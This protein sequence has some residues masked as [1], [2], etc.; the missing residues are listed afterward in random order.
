MPDDATNRNLLVAWRDGDQRAA[1]VLVQRYMLRLMALARSRLSRKLARRID[2][3]DIV[4]SAWRSFF[5]GARF[6]KLSPSDSDDLWPL[7]VTITLRKLARQ[8]TRHAANRRNAGLEVELDETI[9]WHRTVS[10]DPSPSEAALLVDEV[11]SLM[12]RLDQVDRD[13][14]IR[15]LQGEEQSEIAMAIGCSER[16]VRRSMQR[17][18]TLMTEGDAQTF[19]IQNPDA[20]PT[21]RSRTASE[22]SGTEV[23]LQPTYSEKDITL[24]KLIGTGGFGKV[25]RS[26]CRT[27]G[28]MVAVKFLKKQFWNDKRARDRLLH[29]A[30]LIS[31]VSHPAII[32]HF[33]WGMTG[34]GGL[35]IVMDWIDG[36]NAAEWS[37][38]NRK[39][40]SEII[41]CGIVVAEA[42]AAAHEAGLIHGDLTPNNVLRGTDGRFVLTDFG[43]AKLVGDTSQGAVGG[44]PGFLAP[45]QISDSYGPVGFHTDV[46]GFGGMLYALLTGIAPMQGRDTP[47]ILANVL[48]SRSPP[49]VNEPA[50]GIPQLLDDL[51]AA[52]LKK[53]PIERP[54]SMAEV[55]AT[56]RTIERQL[57]NQVRINQDSAS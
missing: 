15:R 5:V 37:A 56:L 45:E 49:P 35:F 22:R 12:K 41:R 21:S 20:E 25:Y 9:D 34:S 3:E 38:Q 57:N 51:L 6:G 29:E 17:I 8:A 36:H 10:R 43:F 11:E 19:D 27:S 30:Q 40:V 26:V 44:T 48:S 42:V 4:M 47:E 39:S 24:Q 33:G 28:S 2:P 31:N 52:C 54:S 13:I 16:T 50:N 32:R 7:L 55:A 23:D 1:D 46:Y 53:E 14:L 18:R